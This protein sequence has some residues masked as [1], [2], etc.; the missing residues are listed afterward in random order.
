MVK[1][2]IWI[3]TEEKPRKKAIRLIIEKMASDKHLRVKFNNIKILPMFRENRFLFK[4]KILG[5]D[6]ESINDIFLKIVSGGS[7]FVDYLVFLQSKEPKENS[8]PLYIVEETKTADVESRNTSVYQRC[9]KFVYVDFYYPDCKK[10][11]LYNIK[12]KSNKLPT[13]TNIFGTR[14]LLTL[15]VEI[16]GRKLNDNVFKKFNSVDELIY[17][18]NKMKPPP[19]SNIP[20]KIKKSKDKIF[21][22]GRLYK[23]GGLNHDPNIGALTVIS[24]TLRVLGWDKEIIIVKHQLKQKHIGKRNKFV[25]IANQLDIKLNGLILPSVKLP[26]KYWYYETRSEKIVT[27]FLHILFENLNNVDVIY[28][29][30]AGCERGYFKTLSGKFLAIRKY[31]GG[32]KSMGI[33]KLP[34]L[35]VC[36]FKRKKI[37]CIEGKRYEMKEKGILNLKKFSAIEKEYINRYYPG[38]DVERYIVLYGGYVESITRKEIALL[39]TTDGKIIIADHTPEVI[40]DA[41]KNYGLIV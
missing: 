21:I 34:D 17:F 12:I 39:L 29:N 15:G 16:I 33:I 10:I 9:S 18:K 8:K 25:Q 30:H 7:S 14:M 20:I 5:I 40:K 6:V 31:I 3:L 13:D 37:I 11:M 38:Y 23:S 2:N 22:S 27:I 19:S 35:I 36:D 26:E 1:K 28:E 41:L 32:D 4:Y 24:K